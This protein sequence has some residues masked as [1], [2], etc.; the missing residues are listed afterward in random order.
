VRFVRFFFHPCV[1]CDPVHFPRLASIIGEC[2]VKTTRIWSDA[3]DN[4]PNENCPAIQSFL[5]KEL[6]ASI[7]KFANCGWAHSAACAVAEIKAP[8]AGIQDC[9]D[10][11]TNLRSGLRSGDIELHQ[12]CATIPHLPDGRSAIVF[13]P[14]GGT[15]QRTL[16]TL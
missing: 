4:K 6:A 11:G 7:F 14:G 13:D 10:A 12:V 1:Y 15:G 8:L 16:E 3:R 9:I 5:V 2:L